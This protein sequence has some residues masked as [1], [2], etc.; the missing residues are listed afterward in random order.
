MSP[1]RER[2]T[3][4]GPGLHTGRPCA[5]TIT[6]AA[7]G[8]GLVFS[9]RDRAGAPAVAASWRHVVAT[10]RR[11][12]LGPV[13]DPSAAVETTEHLL[14]ALAGTGTWDALVE[15]DGPEVPILDG[16]ALAMARAFAAW[17]PQAPP[18]PLL[19][20]EPVV[21][22]RGRARGVAAPSE[23]FS[24]AC[25][26]EFEHPA[27]GVQRAAWDG[28]AA[29]FL[30]EVAPARTFGFLDEVDALRRRGLVAGGSLDSALVFG[31]AGPLTP[32]RFADEPARHKLLDAIGDLALLG[33]PLL[34]RVDLARPGHALVLELVR[35][36]AEVA[37]VRGERGAAG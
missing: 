25:E 29:G 34:A 32:P 28:S 31:P 26:L 4:E 12:A 5:V 33:H 22:E 27:V 11:T 18:A 19:L 30:A 3:F 6:R 8:H 17:G 21:V 16:S 36:I 9:R 7:P 24:L 15:V 20:S 23:A 35:R 10:D 2:A 14:A 13:G 37:R 1:P